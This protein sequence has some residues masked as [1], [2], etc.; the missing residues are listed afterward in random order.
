[1]RGVSGEVGVH[2]QRRSRIVAVF[3]HQLLLPV[4][5]RGLGRRDGPI[6]KGFRRF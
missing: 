2:R 3:G 4:L 5:C 1:M 6:D